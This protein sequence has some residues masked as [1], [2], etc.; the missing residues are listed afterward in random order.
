MT[1]AVGVSLVLL[2]A[3]VACSSTPAPVPV[4]GKTADLQQLAG[5]WEG[6]Y[7]SEA[8]GRSGTIV[9]KLAP[10]EDHA[11][12]D[13]LMVPR[14]GGEPYRRTDAAWPEAA[15]V[16][17]QLLVIRFVSASEGTVTGTLEPY[18]DPSCDCTVE[19]TFT[20]KLQGDAIEGTFSSSSSRAAG[21]S[22]GRWRV[23]RKTR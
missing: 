16:P 8:T 9:F 22:G 1:R 3:L 19:T 2:L 6:E 14:G 13:V 7:S 23:T 15:H 17:G 4:E 11:H 5:E 20:G 21:R 12:G 18:R 10:G